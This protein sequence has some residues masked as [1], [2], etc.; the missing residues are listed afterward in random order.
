MP[1]A[2]NEQEAQVILS[3]LQSVAADLFARQGVSK[4]SIEDIIRP[5]RIAKGSFYKFYPSKEA[6]FFELIE[7]VQ[8][9]VRQPLITTTP[10]QNK[11]GKKQF[12]TLLL[13]AVSIIKR[14]PLLRFLGSSDELMQ[15]ARKVPLATLKQHQ[16]DDRQFIA[17][18]VSLWNRKK[19]PPTDEKVAAHFSLLLLIQYND[20]LLGDTLYPHA[21][22]AIIT[23]FVR[24][25]FD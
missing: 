16:D 15:V 12:E 4:T 21:E 7:G 11:R 2:F 5:V 1:R 13:D 20:T 23:S 14:E 18:L 17:D 22:S 3:S 10:H 8:N 6:L 19:K 25:F 24:C 9:R